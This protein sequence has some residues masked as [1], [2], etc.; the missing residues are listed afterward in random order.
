MRASSV[1]LH[2]SIP[3]CWESSP[4][5]IDWDSPLAQLLHLKKIKNKKYSILYITPNLLQSC[6]KIFSKNSSDL[7]CKNS[8]G[9]S[10]FTPLLGC[11]SSPRKSTVPS[12]IYSS[13]YGYPLDFCANLALLLMI[14]N[15]WG[16]VLYNY[17]KFSVFN[18]DIMSLN[19][20]PENMQD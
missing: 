6:Y 18:R 16:W 4:P 14:L 3:L 15:L 5:L 1:F 19:I 7:L 2:I 10:H 9:L 20:F 12:Y 13:A 8:C 17:I 11:F